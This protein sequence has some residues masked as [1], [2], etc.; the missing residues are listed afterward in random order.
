MTRGNI[1]ILQ[2]LDPEID[3][4][5]HR[6][7]RHNRN[8]SLHPTYSVTFLDSPDT[9][10]SVHF[11]HFEHTVHSNYFDIHFEIDNMAQ[12]P[13][14]ERTMSELTTLEFT[15]HSLCIQYPEE[16]IL[17]VLKTGLIHLLPKFH[18]LAGEGPC[19]HLK[20]FHVVCS[21][22]KPV[23]VQEDHVYLKTFLHFLKDNAKDWLYYLAP[24]SITSWDDLKRL[25]VTKLFH[26]SRTTTIEKEISDIKQ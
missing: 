3:R 10:V 13:P 14:H 1:G 21:T 22:M 4:T 25:F 16:E 24:R 7:V 18:G 2:S 12:P 19:K 26:A 8:P 9:F 15:Y 20:Q 5:F 11:D 6:G 17:Y 23:D